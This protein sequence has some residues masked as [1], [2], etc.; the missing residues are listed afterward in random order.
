[1]ADPLITAAF[2]EASLG[3]I[4]RFAG[5]Q[6][7]LEAEVGGTMIQIGDMLV[8]DMQ[9]MTWSVF[10][11]P[12]GNLADNIRAV[13]GGPMAVNIEVDVPYSWRM[14]EGF[15]GADSLGRVYDEEG[16][17]YAMPTLEADSDKIA[18]MMSLA[19]AEAIAKLGV[20]L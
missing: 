18:V 6:A 15:H 1:M 5:F 17:P 2:D 12:T 7:I 16:K 10:A 19:V 11:N 3:T 4:A 14:E 20:P 13:T 9:S 8:P